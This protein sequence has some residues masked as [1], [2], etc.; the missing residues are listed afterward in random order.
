[1][2]EKYIRRIFRNM[3]PYQIFGFLLIAIPSVFFLASQWVSYPIITTIASYTGIFWAIG[4]AF[5]VYSVLPYAWILGG[6]VL[7]IYLLYMYITKVYLPIG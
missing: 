3:N 5:L 1:M 4:A 6:V 2:V 7:V